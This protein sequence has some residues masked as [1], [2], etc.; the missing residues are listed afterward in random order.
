MEINRRLRET[1]SPLVEDLVNR[2]SQVGA[3]VSVDSGTGLLL[4]NGE[5]SAELVLSRCRQT[6]SGSLRWRVEFGKRITPDI[7]ILGRMDE[8]NERPVDY[9]LLPIMDI[10]HSHLLLCESNGVI[11]DTYQFDNLEFFTTLAARGRFR[12]PHDSRI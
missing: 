3:T 7:T 10:A 1:R 9:Y 12:S 8:S 4:I 11:L 6:S 2:L 5:Y